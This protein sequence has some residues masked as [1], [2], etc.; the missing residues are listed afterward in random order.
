MSEFT[1]LFTLAGAATGLLM[2]FLVYLVVVR[3][4]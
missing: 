2:V 1:D 3:N 4:R